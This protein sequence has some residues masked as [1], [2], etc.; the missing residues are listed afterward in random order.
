M[1]EEQPTLPAE[2]DARLDTQVRDSL[3]H[4]K[5]TA[6][7][8]EKKVDQDFLASFNED[9][10][11]MQKMMAEAAADFAAADANGDGLLDLGEYTTFHNQ[12]ITTWKGRGHFVDERPDQIGITFGILDAYNT[13]T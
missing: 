11:A 6:T 2:L 5:V 12:Q 9:P 4:W 10:E 8:D 3:Q 7:E 1:A 13:E